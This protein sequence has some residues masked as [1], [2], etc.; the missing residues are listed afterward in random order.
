ML[1]TRIIS[2]VIGIPVL[3]FILYQGGLAWTA[4]FVV[5]AVFALYEYLDMM[6]K[7]GHKPQFIIAYGLLLLMLFR[8]QTA[9]YFLPLLL[10]VIL[11]IVLECVLMYPKFSLEDIAINFLGA[12]YI[13]FL[14]SF[15]LQMQTIEQPFLAMLLV[16][17]VTWGSD[18]GGYLFGRLWG[19][20]KMAPLLSP[21]K[22]WAGAVGGVVLASAV[23]IAFGCIFPMNGLTVGQILIMAVI[24]SAVAQ[25]GD[26]FE[27]GMKRYF[28]VKDSGNIIPGHG[29]VLD[30]FDSFM[31]LL[32]V[33]YYFIIFF[34]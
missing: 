31:L 30:R 34:R 22:T 14:F 25:L 26:L 19:K 15:A 12:F 28:G 1:K 6:R 21:N 24:G 32:P 17:L 11:L 16:L 4:L 5:L 9:Q 33:I 29:G 10:A 13:G 7:H 3:L 2:A 8:E 18:I 23:A 20:N 27:S